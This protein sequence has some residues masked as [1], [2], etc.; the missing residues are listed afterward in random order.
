MPTEIPGFRESEIPDN[1]HCSPSLLVAV[2][3]C[4]ICPL[5]EPP[6][7]AGSNAH[8]D[9]KTGPTWETQR[10]GQE[11]TT[12]ARFR[13]TL[14]LQ[15]GFATPPFLSGVPSLASPSISRRR[16][17]SAPNQERHPVFKVRSKVSIHGGGGGVRTTLLVT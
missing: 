13:P 14:G 12:I 3:E 4:G 5:A 8:W 7:S 6:V 9:N 2:C 16:S 1:H 15:F 17:A 10:S 11:S